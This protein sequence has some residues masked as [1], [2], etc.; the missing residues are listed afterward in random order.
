ML[1]RLTDLARRSP[2]TVVGQLLLELSLDCG[3][4]YGVRCRAR[5]GSA[6]VQ[7]LQRW[8]EWQMDRVSQQ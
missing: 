5:G 3:I 2:A 6:V 7:S 1:P 8:A 4:P